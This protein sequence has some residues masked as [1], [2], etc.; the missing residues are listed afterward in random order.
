MSID[1]FWLLPIRYSCLCG[2]YYYDKITRFRW[3]KLYHIMQRGRFDF[4]L[5]LPG[6]ARTCHYCRL[7]AKN[8]AIP[9]RHVGRHGFW[10][11]PIAHVIPAWQSQQVEHG[12]QWVFSL[13]FRYRC[14]QGYRYSG[15][16]L[17]HFLDLFW[18]Y[19]STALYSQGAYETIQNSC[20]QTATPQ[21]YS[22]CH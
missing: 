16:K 7:F 6:C 13:M 11:G 18:P 22:L 20:V 21:I 1:F 15:G 3:L 19:G 2:H 17:Y 12:A 5:A 14:I 10:Y 4:F 9:V 8:N